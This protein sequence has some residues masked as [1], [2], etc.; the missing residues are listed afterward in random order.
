MA[1]IRNESKKPVAI[2]GFE[3]IGAGAE[4][5]CSD[6]DAKYLSMNPAL[7]MIEKEVSF[8]AIEEEAPIKEELPKESKKKKKSKKK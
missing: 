4:I 7:R 8:K 2:A 3:L 6:K 5:E 1:T